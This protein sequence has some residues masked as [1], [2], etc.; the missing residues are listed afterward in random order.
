[1]LQDGTVRRAFII[2]GWQ[3]NPQQGWYP[4]LGKLLEGRGFKVE[5]PSM[6]NNMDPQPGEWVSTLSKLVAKPDENT[7]LIGHSAGA[8]TIMK[9]LAEARGRIGGAVLVAPWPCL[10][11]KDRRYGKEMGGR[12]LS[13]GYPWSVIRE[14]AKSIAALF[15]T[16]DP[17]VNYLDSEI[18]EKELHCKVMVMRGWAHFNEHRG[19]T[20]LPAAY[21]AVMEEAG[22]G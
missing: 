12:W 21:E 11:A 14:N 6:P 1:M 7:Y 13:D 2:H 18:F 9:Y 17:Y 5:I 19:I 4:W 8:N 15:S 10:K 22:L 3:G 16:N 20:E